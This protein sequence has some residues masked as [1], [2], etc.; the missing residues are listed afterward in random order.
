MAEIQENTTFEFRSVARNLLFVALAVV[1]FLMKR[2]YAGP[3]Q[4]LIHSY[5]GNVTVSFA[6]YFAFLRL[7][8]MSPRF[9]RF[10]AAALVLACVE[11]FELFDGF[12]FMTNSYDSFDL[13]ANA[14]GVGFALGLDTMLSKN[15]SQNR[16]IKAV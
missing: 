11:S 14:I 10:I 8:M 5:A 13:L 12:G 9:G 16:D 2:Q 7:C 1:L 4:E 6:L 3:F 15:P